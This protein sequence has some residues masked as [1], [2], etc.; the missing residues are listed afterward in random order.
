MK[1]ENILWV[2]IWTVLILNAIVVIGDLRYKTRIKKLE[3][4]IEFLEEIVNTRMTVERDRFEMLSAEVGWHS[5]F[6]VQRDPWT[7]AELD[8]YRNYREAWTR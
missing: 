3:E 8:K 6:W 1:Y 7:S 5:T 4:K 2:L